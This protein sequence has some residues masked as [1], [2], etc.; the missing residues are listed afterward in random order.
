M[1]H[2]EIINDCILRAKEKGRLETIRDSQWSFIDI[3]EGDEFYYKQLAFLG[4][5]DN[6]GYFMA[7]GRQNGDL[8]HFNIEYCDTENGRLDKISEIIGKDIFYRDAVLYEG[9][10]TEIIGDSRIIDLHSNLP[11][12]TMAK[13]SNGK[14]VDPLELVLRPTVLGNLSSVDCG[15]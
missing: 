14:V 15:L 12:K 2:F 4:K 9:Y 8:V 1:A 6:E 10:F 7:E 5:P 11:Y 13:L 3:D